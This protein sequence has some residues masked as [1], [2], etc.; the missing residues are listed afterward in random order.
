MLKKEFVARLGKELGTKS[1]PDLTNPK[2]FRLF[3]REYGE[4]IRPGLKAI[5]RLQARSMAKAFTKVVR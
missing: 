2:I 3:C 4:A 5:D 1:H